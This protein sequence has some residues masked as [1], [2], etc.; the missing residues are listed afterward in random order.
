MLAALHNPVNEQDAIMGF[1]HI[2]PISHVPEPAASNDKAV[3]NT[4]N[5]MAATDTQ[6]KMAAYSLLLPSCVRS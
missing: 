5:A 3:I 2:K 4:S 1:Q 6:S